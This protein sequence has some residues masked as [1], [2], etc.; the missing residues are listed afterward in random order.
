[1]GNEPES[2]EGQDASRV[3]VSRA[4]R[5]STDAARLR[6]ERGSGIRAIPLI[7]KLTQAR[8]RR[9]NKSKKVKVKR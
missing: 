7:K 8:G 3:G 5:V 4:F 2:T 9:Q 1:L 6:N